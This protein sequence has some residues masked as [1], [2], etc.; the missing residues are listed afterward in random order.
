MSILPRVIPIRQRFSGPRVADI[1]EEVGKQLAQAGTEGRIKPGMRI[2]I[3]AGSRGIA[4]IPLI[5]RS[6]VRQLKAW[7][8]EPFI[9]PSMGSHGGATAEG[10]VEVL[11]GLGVTEAF[12]EAPILSSMDVVEIGRTPAG[13]PVHLDKNAWGA[14]GIVVVA[15]VKAHT[16][17]QSPV[18]YESGLMKMMSIGLGKHKQALLLHDYGVRGIR[19]MMP[20]VARVVLAN[21]NIVAGLAVLENAFEE[22]AKIEAVAPG[23]IPER[24]PLL[25]A[26]SKSFMPRL[27]VEDIDILMVDRIGKNVSGTGMDTNIIGR[28]RIRG[29]EEFASPRIQCIIAGDLSAE[30]HGNAVGIGLADVTTRRLFEKI[31]RRITNANVIT[32]TFLER[33]KIPLVAENDRDALDTALRCNWGVPRAEARFV[34]IYDTL[35]LERLYVSESLLAE[36]SGRA[37]IEVLGEAEEIRLDR[38]GNFEPFEH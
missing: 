20:E 9:V 4:N 19:D 3:T 24:E 1:P 22:T 27:P 25:L 17:F 13:M 10:Q 2:A 32:S 12:C 18:G 7:G 11:E 14:D 37:G 26:E 15:R 8:A 35:H 34:R 31:D 28:M 29:V 36:V 23:Q 33:G 16:D 6:V 38:D 5:L 30:S 21:A